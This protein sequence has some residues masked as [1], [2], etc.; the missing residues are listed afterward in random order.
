[1]PSSGMFRH[2]MAL[3][4]GLEVSCSE[5]I[6]RYAIILFVDVRQMKKEV[7]ILSSPMMRKSEMDVSCSMT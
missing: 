1:M 4:V 3:S 2:D 6:T 5:K 7:H